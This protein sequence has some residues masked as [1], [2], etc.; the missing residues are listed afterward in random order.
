M[1][2]SLKSGYNT[3]FGKWSLSHSNTAYIIKTVL[4]KLVV[5]PSNQHVYSC[6]LLKAQ[7][8][9][10]SYKLEQVGSSAERWLKSRASRGLGTNSEL[11]R[12]SGLTAGQWLDLL[13]RH[14]AVLCL[15]KNSKSVTNP[16][17]AWAMRQNEKRMYQRCS[18][19]K[20]WNWLPC[21]YCSVSEFSNRVFHV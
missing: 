18:S 6:L 7:W 15:C 14:T 13:Q 20:S 17:G 19:Q 21:F 8:H 16:S 3:K 11:S 1:P 4:L 12:H 9:V 10:D 5:L 2:V